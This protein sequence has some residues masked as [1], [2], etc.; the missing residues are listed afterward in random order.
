MLLYLAFLSGMIA[1]I[2]L[3]T[4]TG[5][6]LVNKTR[7]QHA[8]DVTAL[9]AAT[10]L[11]NDPTRN[12]ANATASA[13]NTFNLFINA[14][15]NQTLASGISANDLSFQYS[16]T[17]NPFS[18]GTSPANFVRV[19]TAALFVSPVLRQV[20]T[21]LNA[22][23]VNVPGVSTAG[24]AGLPCDLTPLVVCPTNGIVGCDGPGDNTHGANGLPGCNG[25]SFN[26]VVCLKGGTQAA[27]TAG[28]DCQVSDTPTGNFGLVNY[29][30]VGP[31]GSN[32]RDLLAGTSPLCGGALGWENGNKVGPVS[33]GIGDRF[34]ADTVQTQ[35][36]TSELSTTV[37]GYQPGS[38][39]NLYNDHYKVSQNPA[40]N[41]KRVMQV[42]V[43]TDC[44]TNPPQWDENNGYVACLFLTQRAVQHGGINEIYGELLQT[45]PGTGS[46][47]PKTNILVGP[48]KVVLFKSQG[49]GDS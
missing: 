6:I 41:N 8:L 47:V 5:D 38:L 7:L 32:V 46:I 43:V 40:P 9:S 20:L 15:G 26:S 3:A 30:D 25:V 28:G 31:G 4:D 49:S 48:L 2:G 16:A 12:T 37:P 13:I 44:T 33:Q 19:S 36:L 24:V 11:N 1:M 34:D 10:I 22:G 21:T 35:Y 29:G 14:P 45:C 18:S 17:L 39:T 27:R 42:P 23:P